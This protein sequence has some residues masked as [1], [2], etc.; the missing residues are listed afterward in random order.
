[1]FGPLEALFNETSTFGTS[2]SQIQD[3]VLFS[4]TSC[5]V[6]QPGELLMKPTHTEA[7]GRDFHK[8]RGPE[9]MVTDPVFWKI[10]SIL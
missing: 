10:V 3:S 1:M 2:Y 7:W 9:K 6:G 5:H 4:N 8:P